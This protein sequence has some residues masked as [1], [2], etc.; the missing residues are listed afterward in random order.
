MNRTNLLL[1]GILALV[2][3]LWGL[4]F[5]AY[6]LMQK[7]DMFVVRNVD[8]RGAERADKEMLDAVA[9]RFI[10]TNI[11]DPVNVS[12]IAEGDVWIDKLVVKRQFPST[13]VIDVYEEH[14]VFTYKIK[15]E[16]AIL[17]ANGVS[18]PAP[19]KDSTVFS[20][21]AV[22]KSLMAQLAKLYLENEFFRSL[23]V[24]LGLSVFTVKLDGF[25]V[26]GSYDADAFVQNWNAFFGGI[27][28][29][30]SSIEYV[31]LTVRGKIFVRGKEHAS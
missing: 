16:C 2:L 10:G 22:D 20:Q 1:A 28:Q 12:D 13:L 29:R 25:S 14:P 15:N 18:I 9:R 4:G 26:Y 31:D 27:R 3:G 24:E 6:A 7:S 23:R 30:Y 21:V 17:T 11:F 5:G 8:L 19:C